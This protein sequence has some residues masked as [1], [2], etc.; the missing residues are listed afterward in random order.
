MN[1]LWDIPTRTSSIPTMK[2]ILRVILFQVA[3]IITLMSNRSTRPPII[4]PSGGTFARFCFP[5]QTASHLSN[6]P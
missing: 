5:R 4:I 2:V 1:L 6:H 3:P